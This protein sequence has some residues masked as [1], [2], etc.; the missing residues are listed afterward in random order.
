MP[1]NKTNIYTAVKER[2]YSILSVKKRLKRKG[3]S[4]P[5]GDA[6]K[7]RPHRQ[8]RGGSPT[9]PWK[10]SNLEWKSRE[11]LLK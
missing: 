9:A 6:G 7:E 1:N 5:M 8:S 3:C 4:T 11:S 10:A 2:L